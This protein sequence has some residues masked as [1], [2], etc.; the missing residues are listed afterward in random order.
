MKDVNKFSNTKKYLNQ[1]K[2]FRN[3][4]VNVFIG[5]TV[6]KK[7]LLS[8]IYIIALGTVL[9]MTPWTMKKAY[10]WDFFTA[11]FNASSAFSDT[12]LTWVSP[13]NDMKF[14]GQLV[15]LL[16]IQ[17]GGV[18]IM[19][20][21]IILFILIGKNIGISERLLLQS[22]RGNAKLGGT[23]Q[24]I[25]NAFY[26]LFIVEIIGAVV[27]FFYFYFTRIDYLESL[28]TQSLGSIMDLFK[29]MIPINEKFQ[30]FL[31]ETVP[32]W[33]QYVLDRENASDQITKIIS[34][35]NN[36]YQGNTESFFLVV[37]PEYLE[38]LVNNSFM[39]SFHNFGR[40]F[41]SGIFH[42]VSATNNA[43]FDII[44]VNSL[45]PYKQHYFVQF[46][47][48]VQL[49]IGGIGYPV[50][51]DLKQKTLARYRGMKLNFS[52]FTK[53]SVIYYFVIAVVGIILV[54]LIEY[55]VPVAQNDQNQLFINRG[56][57]NATKTHFEGNMAII[58]SVFSTRSA[59]FSTVDIN[60]FKAPTKFIFSILMWIGASPS[61]TGGGIRTTTL[62]LAIL[63]VIASA[64]RKTSINMFKTKVVNETVRR[65][66]AVFIVA[67][68]IIILVTII[69]MVENTSITVLEGIFMAT[70]AFG[71]SGLTIIADFSAKF[72]DFGVV[73][74]LAL[75]SLMFMGQLGVSNTLLLAAKKNEIERFSYLEQDVPIG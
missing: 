74:K 57:F 20:L 25:K 41:W 38:K 29:K 5:N 2:N 35:I 39:V 58:F 9:L 65:A 26:V 18:G 19:T 34:A 70:S 49:V 40:S 64:K 73:S 75:I 36:K 37:K 59:G 56:V 32:D 7:I 3:F 17:I 55:L 31:E 63:S 4:L 68:L 72:G 51:F 43:G 42:S 24:L 44:G 33:S 21:K 62:V 14:F 69:I 16:L 30:I 71:T 23:V 8:Y 61:S 10:Q 53:I 50:F 52:L 67:F 22:E 6:N 48:L 11:L 45:N 66:T 13:A 60:Y 28:K 27:L 1:V 12:G 54:M 15:I 46:I 47:F